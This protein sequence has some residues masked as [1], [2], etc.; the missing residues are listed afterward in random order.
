MLSVFVFAFRLGGKFCGDL[1][2]DRIAFVC[3]VGG[4]DEVDGD[5][6]CLDR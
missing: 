1:L 3:L 5:W 6:I 2:L 4:A